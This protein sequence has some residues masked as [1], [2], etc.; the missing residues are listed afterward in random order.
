M[1]GGGG[2]N[3]KEEGPLLGM[4]CRVSVRV[5][6]AGDLA[7]AVRDGADVGC[8][9]VGV[10]VVDIL[11]AR[12]APVCWEVVHGGCVVVGEVRERGRE[13]EC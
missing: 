1:G 4:G 12:V 2:K 13:G 3:I 7:D 10:V 5:A 8:N 6:K 9:R 11:G